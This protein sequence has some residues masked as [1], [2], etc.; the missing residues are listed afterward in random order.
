MEIKAGPGAVAGAGQGTDSVEDVDG[1]VGIGAVDEGMLE[2]G[3]GAGGGS[4][5]G[6]GRLEEMDRAAVAEPKRD[7]E[8]PYP[9]PI[10]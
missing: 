1:C 2:V 6:G 9:P 3:G 5:G 4:G 10:L 8:C 7:S